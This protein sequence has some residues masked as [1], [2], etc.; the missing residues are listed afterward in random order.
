MEVAPLPGIFHCLFWCPYLLVA[1]NGCPDTVNI[2]SILCSMG[3][4][5][6]FLAF[7]VRA[8]QA[9]ISTSFV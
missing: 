5:H 6:P 2:F 9:Q 1:W 3:W 4:G 8:S 7:V